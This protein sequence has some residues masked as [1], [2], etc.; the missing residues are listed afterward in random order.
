MTNRLFCYISLPLAFACGLIY[1]DRKHNE[2][3]LISL[4]HHLLT[5]TLLALL[6]LSPS[7]PLMADDAVASNT[8]ATEGTNVATAYETPA[9]LTSEHVRYIAGYPDGM[10]RPSGTVTRAEAAAFIT[11]LLVDDNVGTLPCS[12][13]DVA[14]DDWFAQPVRSVCSLGLMADG[15]T[16][17]P[18]DAITRAEFVHMLAAFAPDETSAGFYD[19]DASYWAYDAINR[20]AAAGWIGGFP[21]GSFGP[22]RTLT[23]AEA[24]TIINRMTNRSGDAEQAPVLLDLGL[25]YDIDSAHWAGVAIAE[26]SIGHSGSVYDAGETWTDVDYDSLDLDSGIHEVNGFLYAVDR[27]GS[28]LRNQNVGAYV[29]DNAGTLIQQSASYC[30]QAPYISQLDG[31]GASQGCEP[32]A[33]LAGLKGKGFAM[34]VTP[35]AFLNALPYSDSNPEYGFV[36]SPY[37][38]DGRYTSINPRPLVAYANSYCGGLGVCSNFTGATVQDVQRELLAGNTIVAYQ[39]MYWGNLRYGSFLIDGQYTQ[40][41]ANNHARL[42]LGYDPSLGYFVSD[43]YNDQNR[44]QTF[45]YWID[46]TTFERLWNARKMG[47]VIR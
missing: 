32:I 29:A 23:R 9:Q 36:G 3:G 47:V 17:R 12:Y 4:R 16:Y 6:F 7:L 10:V 11:R 40:M 43:P 25:Y 22:E 20:V 5:A 28:L 27:Y 1:N 8:E 39:T 15:A 26:G 46:A 2:K 33:M 24:C 21:D 44:G 30:S 37:Y 41:V 19:V 35:S 13:T 38:Y 34:D 42:V 31:L 14:D 45:Q 18:N